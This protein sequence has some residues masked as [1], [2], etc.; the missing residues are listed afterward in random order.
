MQSWLSY[1]DSVIEENKKFLLLLIKRNHHEVVTQA[2]AMHNAVFTRIDYLQCANCCKSIPPIVSQTDSRRI[3]N[4]LKINQSQFEHT[5]LRK[6]E[7]GDT[8]IN[9]SPCPFL[10]ADNKC[11]IYVVRPKAC[12]EYPHTNEREFIKNIRLHIQNTHYCPAVYHIIE[13][14]KTQFIE[15]FDHQL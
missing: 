6:D 9:Q 5:C 13:Q 8:V 11:R 2:D 4:Y 14:L 12:C 10:Q 3:S 15:H 1:R 7:D